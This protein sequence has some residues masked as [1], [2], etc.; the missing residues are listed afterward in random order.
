[1]YY[2]DEMSALWAVVALYAPVFI[3]IVLAIYVVGVVAMWKIFAK[4]GQP[5]WAAI[6]PLYNIYILFK[7]TWGKGILFLLMLIPIVNIV[8]MIMTMMKLSKAFGKGTGF[9]I[10]LI[11]LGFIFMLILGFDKSQYVGVPK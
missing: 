8:I 10:G 2:Y 6:V 3:G 1:M 11:F 9:G 4:A 7:I 5:G